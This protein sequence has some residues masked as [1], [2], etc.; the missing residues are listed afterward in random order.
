MKRGWITLGSMIAC[1]QVLS[2]FSG[3]TT[4]GQNVYHDYVTDRCAF[5]SPNDPWFRGMIFRTHTG[6][7]GLFY[8]CDNEEA[9]R[10][11]PWIRWRQ[12]PCDDLL[13]CRRIHNE[14]RQTI[15]NAHQRLRMG[16]CQDPCQNAWGFG[17]PPGAGYGQ[18]RSA[19]GEDDEDWSE[20]D[21]APEME[22]IR[23]SI[24]A[25]EQPGAP[26]APAP[27]ELGS[28][29]SLRPSNHRTPGVATTAKA[30]DGYGTPGPAT[31]RTAQHPTLEEQPAGR[32][33]RPATR[34][35]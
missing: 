32:S 13:S 25:R 14:W 10:C 28:Y 27:L 7:D 4:W 23:D 16:S 18:P 24:P 5:Y 19:T 31:I 29:G 21:M 11:S 22:P 26:S 15:E 9:K 6:H 30:G 2:V 8:N 17:Y 20:L 3:P 35:R 1:W 33:L 12:R 34:Q